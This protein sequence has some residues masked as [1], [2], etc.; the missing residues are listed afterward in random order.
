MCINFDFTE[1]DTLA[2]MRKVLWWHAFSFNFK[3]KLAPCK[4]EYSISPG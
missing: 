4:A 3:G 1:A 2:D